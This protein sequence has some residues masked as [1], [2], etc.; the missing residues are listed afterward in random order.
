MIKKIIFAFSL[1]LFLSAGYVHA[2]SASVINGVWDRTPNDI[3]KLFGIAE[4]GEL[5]EIASSKIGEDGAFAFSF[6]PPKEGYYVIGHTPSNMTNRYT[7]YF[8]P[9]DNLNL[10]VLKESYEL[11]GKNT[12]ENEEMARWHDFIFPLEDKAI[13]F[14]SKPSTYKDFFPLLEDKL[15]EVEKYP[16]ASTPNAVF[17]N[18]F[19]HF[20]KF[21]LLS[22]AVTFIMTPRAEQPKENDFIDYYRQINFQDLT[23]NTE[24][25][26]YP[27]G[28]GVLMRSYIIVNRLARE[29]NANQ[30]EFFQNE[31][32]FAPF[33]ND[34]IKGEVVIMMAKTKRTQASFTEY[35]DKFAKFIKT[36][37]QRERLKNIETQ[38]SKN[39]EKGKATD[40]K[41]ADKNGKEIALSDFKGKVVYVDVW[42]TW[43]GPC[44]KELPY[45]KK[46]EAEYQDNKNI[47]FIGVSV[48]RSKDKQKWLDF[49]TAEQLPGIQIFAGDDAN[50]TL[51]KPYKISG[52]P[53]FILVAK[54]GKLIFADAPR[55]SSGEIRSAINSALKD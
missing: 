44:K 43:C 21:D 51:M 42:A 31:S 6:V 13:Y 12:P 14:A 15:K 30:D 48:D 36:D 1:L 7:F 8:K 50:D 19:E 16:A 35:C 47:V 41:F 23:K 11:T 24:S 37:S 40:F 28:L 25:L 2:Q 5:H 3:V 52:I 27:G 49:L 18:S 34:T 29:G 20:K 32:D 26:N 17:N 33:V 55:P 4:N 45:L 9:G 39:I 10:H 38:I 53:R 54:N 46:L 22:N